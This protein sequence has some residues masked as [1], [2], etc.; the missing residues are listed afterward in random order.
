MTAMQP[1]I[2]NVPQDVRSEAAVRQQAL[3][4]KQ[5]QLVRVA[6]DLESRR[7]SLR[8][9]LQAATGPERG[10][11]LRSFGKRRDNLRAST[12]HWPKRA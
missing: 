11:S 3:G 9:A 2:A 7:T 6:V 8:A 4:E 12:H 5:T 10:V 1:V